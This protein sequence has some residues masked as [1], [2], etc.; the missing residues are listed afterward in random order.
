ML[1]N[2]LICIGG[3]LG[4]I[5]FYILY[6]GYF[7]YFLLFFYGAVVLLSFLLSFLGQRFVHATI[8]VSSKTLTLGEGFISYLTVKNTSFLPLTRAK[9]LLTTKNNM[10]GEIETGQHIFPLLEPDL[11]LESPHTPLHTGMIL[12]EIT[13]FYVYDFLGLFAFKRPCPPTLQV[14]ALPKRFSYLA[15]MDTIEYIPVPSSVQGERDANITFDNYDI[16]EYRPGDPLRSIHWK[17]SAKLNKLFIREP[18]P[19]GNSTLSLLF[20][21]FGT[22]TEMDEVFSYLRT[23]GEDAIARKLYFELCWVDPALGSFRIQPVSTNYEFDQFFTHILNTPLP[24]TGIGI[25]QLHSLQPD[26]MVQL[27]YVEP[28]GIENLQDGKRMEGAAS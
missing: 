20:D 15:G 23:F 18:E 17:L 22:P 14:L 7:S 25:T 1:K 16:R 10:S 24:K 12:S 19:M 11:S 27:F 2:R 4:C 13:G 6:R 8:A 9:I 3:F 21:F 28:S 5:L 26:P